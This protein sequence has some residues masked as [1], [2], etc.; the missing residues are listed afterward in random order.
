MGL[1]FLDRIS[2]PFRARN[3]PD[4]TA[5]PTGKPSSCRL[6]DPSPEY[7]AELARMAKEYLKR[8]T[9]HERKR[10]AQAAKDPA[11]Y[12]RHIMD[13]GEGRSL[14]D[15]FVRQATFWLVEADGRIVANSRLRFELTPFLEHEGGHIGY[16]TRPSERRKGYGTLICKLTLQRAKELG[17]QRVLITCD[18]TNAA[19]ARII[20]RNGG[21][22]ENTVLSWETRRPKRRYWVDLA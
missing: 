1:R 8:G 2:A 21:R 13:L 3:A 14:P 20:E 9:Q 16:S 18:E 10:Y 11:G 12:I 4:N 17:F 7:A 22:F 19:S 15:G 6:V 5:G